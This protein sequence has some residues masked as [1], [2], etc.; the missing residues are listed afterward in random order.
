MQTET[1]CGVHA[2]LAVFQTRREAIRRVAYVRELRGQVAELV[3]FAQARRLQCEELPEHSLDRT[4][5]STHHEGLVVY[6]EPRVLGPDRLRVVFVGEPCGGRLKHE[7][8]E[9]SLCAAWFERG[10]LAQL[11]LRTPFVCR[12]VDLALSRSALLP[13]ASVDL[14]TADE[15]RNER[16]CSC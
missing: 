7:P 4:V 13:I 6:T 15:K 11:P 14:M 5:E 1:V 16:P 3:R 9:H 10:E 2:C 8:D 12:M